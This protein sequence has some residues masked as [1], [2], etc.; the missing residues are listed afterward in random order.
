MTLPKSLDEVQFPS[1]CPVSW[2]SM[3]GDGGVR[4]CAECDRKVYNLSAM[5]ADDALRFLQGEGAQECVQLMYRVDGTVV[6]AD[7]LAT[8]DNRGGSLWRRIAAAAMTIVT[9]GLLQGC[10]ADKTAETRVGKT[11]IG[12]EHKADDSAA[13]DGHE[14]RIGKTGVSR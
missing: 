8:R 11:S 10:N 14:K 9:F 3:E 2:E 7:E 13:S 12:D 1:P 6:T 4:H 5:S